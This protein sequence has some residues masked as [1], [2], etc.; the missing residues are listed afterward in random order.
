MTTNATPPDSTGP[1]PD[2]EALTRFL[3]GESAEAESRAVERWL[4][5]NPNDAMLVAAL[6]VLAGG[7][8]AA[9]PVA[10]DAPVDVEHALRV[11]KARSV[12]APPARGAPML[13]L[14]TPAPRRRRAWALGTLAA[15]AAAAAFAVGISRSNRATQAS[16]TPVTVAAARDYSTPV[17][18][19]DTISLSDGSRVLL[20]PGSRLTVA[21]DFDAA[22]ATNRD[23]TLVGQAFFTVHHDDA[24]P[25]RVKS[26]NAILRDVGTAFVVRN[27]SAGGARLTVSVTDGVVALL[28]VNARHAAGSSSDGEFL[29]GRGDRGMLDASGSVAVT[30][31]AVNDDELSWTRGQLVYR[32]A[33][34]A[35][36]S[37]DLQRWY[38]VELRIPDGALARRPLTASFEHDPVERVIQVIALAIGAEAERSA[39]VVTLRPM[40][41]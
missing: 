35:T 21:A 11:V 40:R 19:I 32:G 17:G 4:A 22:T 41:R 30:H 39:N 18:R 37:A 25:F 15:A 3:S 7:E 8:A 23:V 12:M 28:P 31:G 34:L 13:R 16:P 2:W 29:L 27:D 33:S 10:L 36:V 38:G 1:R 26:G 20:A 6:D 5:A 14:M 9:V 24:R